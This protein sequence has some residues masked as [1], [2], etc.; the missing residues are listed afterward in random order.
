MSELPFEAPPLE[1]IAALLPAFEF[2]LLIAQ[3]GMGAVYKGRQKS[4]D[5]DVAIKILPRELGDDPQFRTSFVAEAKA[6]ARLIHPNLIGVFDSGDVDGLLYIVME[7]VDGKSL[8]HSAHNQVIDPKQAVEI[9]MGICAGLGHAH[10]NKIVHR[11][12][13]PANIL[14]T[15]KREPKI[16]DFGLARAA[17]HDSEGLAMGTPGYTAPEVIS[18]PELADQRS[19]IFSVGVIL[20]ELLTGLPPYENPDS[21]EHVP[22]SELLIICKKA[23]HEDP[24]E[25]FPD[26]Q[27]MIG[28]LKSW[29]RPEPTHSTGTLPK[30]Q[31]AKA[32]AHVDNSAS[33][34]LGRNIAIII[35]LL[36]TIFFAWDLLQKKKA[37]T[38][39]QKEEASEKK[40]TPPKPKENKP[41]ANSPGGPSKPSGSKPSKPSPPP[42]VIEK[43]PAE[44]P[45][46]SL[47]RLRDELAD[48][49]FDEL[50]IGT[51]TRGGSYYFFVSKATPW[52]QASQMARAYGG[53]LPLVEDEAFLSWMSGSFPAE[54]TQKS[55]WIG[56][57]Q[58]SAETWQLVSGDPWPLGSAPQGTGGFAMVNSGGKVEA[59]G[60]TDSQPFFIQWH[61]D[62]SNPTSLEA[63]LGRCKASLDNDSPTFPPNTETVGER[64]FLIVKQAC[65]YFEARDLAT[66][67][68]GELMTAATED[69]A[70]WLENRIKNVSAADGLWIGAT[71][72]N[73]L[74][75]WNSL[76]PW[77]FARWASSSKAG[78]GNGL[79]V[80]PGS[81]WN[82]TNQSDEASGFIIEWSDDLQSEAPEIA[83]D[84]VAAMESGGKKR[85]EEYEAA[86]KKAAE[87]NTDKY[88]WTLDIW[89]KRRG[90]NVE[91]TRWTPVVEAAK[92]L[93]KDGRV[94]DVPKAPNQTYPEPVHEIAID[95]FNKQRVIDLGFTTKAEKLRDYYVKALK[96]AANTAREIGQREKANSYAKKI[97]T[98]ADIDSW[99]AIIIAKGDRPAAPQAGAS[100]I[101]IISA[102]FGGASNNADVTALIKK[103]IEVEKRSFKVHHEEIGIDPNPN[104]WNKRI[105]INYTVDGQHFETIFIRTKEVSPEILIERAKAISES[106][107]E[108]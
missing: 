75:S 83:D 57:S 6:M 21:A 90:N 53:H 19:D 7:Y 80:I 38:A 44:T 25:R 43:P 39:A 63:I 67:G 61:R 13:K 22:D 11:D 2:Q 60:S 86:R 64:R 35:V 100:N 81:G 47:L 20:Q 29:L 54:S 27:S 12:I 79:S 24:S 99:I 66:L 71:L 106:G 31:T 52:A 95:Y 23:T 9:V 98:A 65:T 15:P 108:E 51:L 1:S 56:A 59:K 32:A 46:Q 78:S 89:L 18:H 8:H 26:A 50:P 16:G 55:S 62:G 102:N 69:E 30:P 68:G 3:G 28:A 88:T 74:W 36:V 34:A 48:G 10:E 72:Q 82:A 107:A 37:T 85:L 17:G 49:N 76:Q 40:V 4:L 101:T 42:L 91:V 84:G 33:S 103:W 97:D 70:D 73:K 105:K 92:A 94:P 14:L 58:G 87:D 41:L 5:R 77:T 96:K 45:S 93:V 104:N